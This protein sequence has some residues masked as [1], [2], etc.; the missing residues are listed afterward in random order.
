[1]NLFILY[2]LSFHQPKF[3]SNTSESEKL[4]QSVHVAS[5]VG[6]DRLGKSRG[7]SSS[8]FTSDVPLI[9]L[10]TYANQV[11]IDVDL[12]LSAKRRTLPPSR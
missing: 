6:G 1:M 5:N 11:V 8:A 9:L 4:C 12:A 3:L 10:R 7:A 2:D